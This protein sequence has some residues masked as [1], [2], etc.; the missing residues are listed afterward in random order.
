[1]LL[2]L[3]LPLCAAVAELTAGGAMQ[4]R[5][6]RTSFAP[7]CGRTPLVMDLRYLRSLRARHAV[8]APVTVMLGSGHQR[9]HCAEQGSTVT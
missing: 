9:E 1:M 8:S 7:A 2:L 5:V 3:L 6:P 4:S